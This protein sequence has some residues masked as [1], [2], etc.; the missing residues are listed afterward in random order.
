MRMFAANVLCALALLLVAYGC[1]Q[2]AAAP[3]AERAH[4]L[5]QAGA[6]PPVS[7]PATAASRD[8]N[9]ASTESAT[10]QPAAVATPAPTS[11]PL[12]A[13]THS[14]A[15]VLPDLFS[16]G[17][18]G[19]A[20]SGGDTNAASVEEVLAQGLRL[21]GASPAHIAFLGAATEGSV[22][23]EWRGIART[24]EQRE[25]AL[26]FWL[27]LDADAPLPSPAEAERRFMAE[28]DRMNAVY[29]STLKANFRSLA[30]GGLT[31]GYVFLTCY[32]DYAVSEYLLGAGPTGESTKLSVAYDRM[33]EARSY[34]LYKLAHAGGEFGSEALMSEGEYADWLSRI[35]SDVETLL[36]IILGGREAVVFLAPVGAHNAIAVEAWQAVAQWDVQRTDDGTINA[37]RYG[38]HE[39]DPEHTQT[40]AKLKSRVT[41]ATTATATTTPPTRIAGVS[42]LTRYYRD[43]G[44][45]ADITPGD[46]AT[47]TFTPAQPP[48]PYACAGGRAVADPA[49][50]RALVHDCTALLAARD[51]LRGEARLNWRTNLVMS[52]WKGVVTGGTPTRVTRLL[53][54]GEGLNGTIPAELG[55]LFELTHLNLRRNS[56]TGEIPV[57]LGLLANLESLRLSDNDLTGCIPPAL[58]DVPTNDLAS[59][60]LPYCDDLPPAFS[61][62]TYAF[63]VDAGAATGTPV[64]KVSA[65]STG[66]A[67]AYSISAGDAGGE[68]AIATTT[69]RISVAGPLFLEPAPSRALTVRASDGRGG[70]ATTTV[71]IAVTSVCRNGVVVPKPDANPA[72][73]GDCLVLYHGVMRTLAG[74]A[75]LDWSEDSAL[76]DWQ[77]VQTGGEPV[78]VRS[79]LL[80]DLGLNGTIPAELGLLTGLT[81]IDLDTNRLTGA[82]PSQ[83]GDLSNLERLF[84]F[85][86]DLSGAIPSELGRLKKLKRLDLDTNDLSGKIPSDL[87][88][89]SDLTHLYLHDND[90][91]GPIPAALADLSALEALYLSGNS[92]TGEIPARLGELSELRELVLRSNRL[93]GGIPAELGDLAELEELW[94]SDN[95]LTGAIPPA[96]AGLSLERL[97]LSGNALT[98]CVPAGLRGATNDDLDDLGL[99]ECA[100]RAPVFATSSYAFS[101]PENAAT[102]T[103]VGT[104]S[105]TDPDD[106]DAVS[107][108]I[109]AGN[110]GGKF[111]LDAA[112]GALTVAGALD[113]DTAASHTL[114]VQAADGN[115]GVATAT[116]AVSV[117]T[118][119]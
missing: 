28:L 37:V 42:G 102:S 71:R 65:T 63:S 5:S 9:T 72:L 21:A 45:Y 80:A 53:L 83:L 24:P 52:K 82:I 103:P 26:R 106:G 25:A 48:A 59:L 55:S 61:T 88:G 116:V 67:I 36:S 2:D 75:A 100:N 74:S 111:A 16:G 41:A 60:G 57:E 56:L 11:T 47:T 98:G 7:T 94:L 3:Q 64:G 69:G 19:G 76:T 44:A 39:G 30:H 18:R 68:F 32:A 70:V 97:Y 33:G 113:R 87:G 13:A 109:T 112:T 77:G 29:P 50:N 92:L 23:C 91:S 15:H 115:G 35:V 101:V 84:L 58:E 34:E 117:T 6:A 93:S 90:L 14:V 1:G 43:I 12:P 54:P 118:V 20:A 4:S 119:P 8:P 79:L 49:A 89:L 107:Y 105:A 62:S 95:R 31:T 40:L 99:P 27:G 22:R 78:R 81:R 46:N 17:A 66:G 51:T 104:V 38:A 73:V 114:T 96:L 86:N 10:S 85:D 110:G 108:S